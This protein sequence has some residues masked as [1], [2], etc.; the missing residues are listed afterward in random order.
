[1]SHY[2]NEEGN[3]AFYRNRIPDTGAKNL[4]WSE[5][6]ASYQR[7]APDQGSVKEDV[8][9]ELD[10]LKDS[11]SEEE[12]DGPELESLKDSESE[13]EDDG[14]ELE[15]MIKGLQKAYHRGGKL[16]GL[17]EK[18]EEE[19]EKD[20]GPGFEKSE[21]SER[22]TE[23]SMTNSQKEK[24]EERRVIHES[25]QRDFSAR[26]KEL[27][28]EDPKKNSVLG[29]YWSTFGQRYSAIGGGFTGF[30]GSLFGRGMARANKERLL[31]VGPGERKI[32]RELERKKAKSRKGRFRPLARPPTTTSAERLW[33]GDSEKD[34]LPKS[35][36]ENVLSDIDNDSNPNP[37]GKMLR[38]RYQLRADQP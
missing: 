5:Y 25:L 11:E 9:T 30:F 10:S 24:L 2:D 15:R 3:L 32:M 27:K 18:E 31:K 35:N 19:E 38:L 1:M 36:N 22:K 13:E 34:S 29:K 17:R 7:K 23:V 33:E 4:A 12:D 16:K 14:P 6:I 20:V 8:R 26:E 37:I 21:D 28:N